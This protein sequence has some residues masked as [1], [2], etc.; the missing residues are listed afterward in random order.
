V[1]DFL[2]MAFEV[3]N[4]IED[5]FQARYVEALDKAIAQHRKKSEVG[6]R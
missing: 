6:V 5:R 3:R 2:R 4:S 1:E